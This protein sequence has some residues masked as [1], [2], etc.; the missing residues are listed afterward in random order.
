MEIPIS[1]ITTHNLALHMILWQPP[2]HIQ[3]T[4]ILAESGGVNHLFSGEDIE[5]TLQPGETLTVCGNTTIGTAPIFA[6]TINTRKEQKKITK[7]KK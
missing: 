6:A 1:E 7:K 4:G 2:V 5:V 3:I